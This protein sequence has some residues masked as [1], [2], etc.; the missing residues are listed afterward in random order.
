MEQ[1]TPALALSATTLD[2]GIVQ[3]FL[4]F[5]ISNSTQYGTLQWSLVKTADWL[6]VNPTSGTV[7]SGTISVTLTAN[8]VGLAYGNYSTTLTITSNG[9]NKDIPVTLTV[10]NPNAPQLTVSPLTLD[11]G[12]TTMNLTFNIYNTGTGTLRWSASSLQAW[13]TVSP[14][15]DST[16]T[17]TDVVTVQVNRTTLTP[18]SYTGQVQVTSN[19]GTQTIGVQ[20]SVQSPPTLSVSTTQ[21]DFGST[22]TNLTFNISNSGT[23][24]LNWSIASDRTW[25]TI[26]PAN[27]SNNA[28]VNVYVSRTG[29]SAGSYSGTLS[30]SSTG[31]NGSVSVSMAVPTLSNPTAVTLNSPMNIT[32]SSIDLSWTQNNDTDFKQYEVHKSTTVG[33]TPSSSTLVQT[34]TS[35]TTTSTTV[36]GLTQ[37]TTYYFKIRVVNTGNLFS[38][39]NERNAITNSANTGPYTTDVNTIA[40]YHFDETS[41]NTVTDASGN[42]H[43]GILSGTTKTLG[44]YG[45]ARAFSAYTDYI[46]CGSDKSLTPT[47]QVSIEFWIYI[48]DI[49]PGARILSLGYQIAY[50]YSMYFQGTFIYWSVGSD[51]VYTDDLPLYKWIHIAGTYDGS[52]L[53]VYQDGLLKGQSTYKYTFYTLE[54]SANTLRFGY[55]TG[56]NAGIQGVTIDEVRISNIARTPSEFHLYKH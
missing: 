9:G 3:T 7:T 47:T 32:I 14:A 49:N 25:L 53:K 18:S 36:T 8:R 28:S 51:W 42:G 43:T 40:L 54:G 20:I 23:G 41:G 39:S 48:S 30:V 1:L 10:Q 29:L 44:K 12:A 21:L 38:D 35:K 17:E 11:F 15:N 33:F 31:G 19:A 56:Q 50:Q 24:T 6:S 16:R 4:S 37:S 2:F 34:I 22:L 52:I 5:A 27:G 45:N 26:N 13:I 55:T 46:D